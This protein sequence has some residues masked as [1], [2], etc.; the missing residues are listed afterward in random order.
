MPSAN[1]ELFRQAM[2]ERK[3]IVCTYGGFRREICPV[4]LGHTK[5]EEKVLAFQFAGTGSKPLPPGGDWRCLSLGKVTDVVL[6]D[7]RWHSGGDHRAAQSCVEVVDFD[8]N[9]DSPYSPSGRL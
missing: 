1:Y 3:Q 2:A 4:I 6:R 8:V 9:P 7:G 5:G